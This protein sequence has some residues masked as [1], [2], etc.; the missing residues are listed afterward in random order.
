MLYRILFRCFAAT[1]AYRIDTS[2]PH[3]PARAPYGAGFHAGLAKVAA[4]AAK[5]LLTSLSTQIHIKPRALK[6]LAEIR[7]RALN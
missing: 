2:V 3:V 7:D 6:S 4:T 5:S 1:A